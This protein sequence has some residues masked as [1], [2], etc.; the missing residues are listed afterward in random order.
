MTD[1]R[2]DLLPFDSTEELPVPDSLLDQVIGQEKALAIIQQAARQGR[3]ILLMGSPGTG[4]SMLGM[5]LSEL[6]PMEGLE[7]VLVFPNSEERVF[8][9]IRVAKAGEGERIVHEFKAKRRREEASLN[10][11]F[12][13]F[14]FFLV[15]IAGYYAF[16]RGEP[17]FFIAG[18][19]LA[20]LLWGLRGYLKVQGG[21]FPPKLLI[22]HTESS[23]APFV[24][25]T[26][27]QAGAL[28]G[29]VR[30]D[31][32][33]SG[34]VETPTH[35][36]IEAGAIHWA[37]RGVLYIDEVATL[38]L[39][40]QL[41]LLTAIQKKR[42]TITGRNPGSSGTMVRTEAIP[43]DFLLVLAGNLDDIDGMH[44]ALRSRIRG[45]GYEVYTNEF[46]DDN[47]ENRNKLAQFVAQEVRKDGKIS[48]FSRG[49]VMEVIG[50]ARRRTNQWGRLSLRLRDLGGL[51]RASGDLARKEGTPLVEADHV[52]RARELVRPLEEQIAEIALEQWDGY[53]RLKSQEVEPG[54][55]CGLVVFKQVKGLVLP[56]RAQVFPALEKGKGKWVS[57]GIFR[58]DIDYL[59]QCLGA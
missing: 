2:Q 1:S 32:F 25:A 53:A 51:V 49:A 42:F 44:P 36:L 11:T 52:I 19:V 41:S 24:D 15:L 45:Y 50:E 31:P 23:R 56:I 10:L 38:G 48:H 39:E 17:G 35:E 8:P 27:F 21:T 55:T 58:L 6:L 37:H 28:L 22:N 18:G 29:D 3:F 14:L 20:V 13:L 46:M 54:R 9:K 59:R 16:S 4:K 33:Q 34:G 26:G 12:W 40:S 30:H 57:P 47:R 7:D 5:A 43:C